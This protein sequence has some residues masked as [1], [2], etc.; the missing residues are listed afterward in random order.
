MVDL[1]SFGLGLARVL[2]YFDTHLYSWNADQLQHDE[3]L[4]TMHE[5]Q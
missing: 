1:V 3:W 4:Q 2:P 5:Q